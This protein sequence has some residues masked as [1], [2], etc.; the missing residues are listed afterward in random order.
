MVTLNSHCQWRE[1]RQLDKSVFDLATR[2]FS[3]KVRGLLVELLNEANRSV[4]KA[5]EAEAEKAEAEKAK[6]PEETILVLDEDRRSPDA[7]T[8]ALDMDMSTPDLPTPEDPTLEPRTRSIPLAYKIS[9]FD[10]EDNEGD[11]VDVDDEDGENDGNDAGSNYET[12][13]EDEESEDEGGEDEDEDGD[14]DENG[15][16]AP[17][18]GTFN[19][20]SI[21]EDVILETKT[22]KRLKQDYSRLSQGEQENYDQE[23]LNFKQLLSLDPNKVY[24]LDDLENEK[25]LDRAL[26]LLYLSK[27]GREEI[28]I[29]VSPHIRYDK[30]PTTMSQTIQTKQRVEEDQVQL[31]LS[32]TGNA[33]L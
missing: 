11:E 24:E 23:D 16:N 9:E 28:Q 27:F 17:D 21:I 18:E 32:I 15:E 30:L 2:S 6:T 1:F 14:E 33:V 10:D 7:E 20:S 29:R 8:F 19:M 22:L 31:S 26:R 13:E 25:V 12:D 4:R 5:H 3:D